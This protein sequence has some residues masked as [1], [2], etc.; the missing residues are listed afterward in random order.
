MQ[1]FSI[2]YIHKN[3]RGLD[4]VFLKILLGIVILIVLILLCPICVLLRYDGKMTVKAGIPFLK[5]RIYPDREDDLLSDELSQKKK[6]K[7]KQ[8]L[9]KKEA[10]A[11]RRREKDRRK[12]KGKK[13]SQKKLS[14]TL[15]Q[16]KGK[17]Y[18]KDLGRIFRF[19]RILAAK[20]GKKLHVKIK[21]LEI[22]AASDDAANTAYLFGALSQAVAYGFA[23]ADK[24]TNIKFKNSRVVVR[25]DFCS[26]KTRV[27]AEI[28]F[29]IRVGSLISFAGSAL[30]LF[31][32]ESMKDKIGELENTP[33]NTENKKGIAL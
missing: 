26:D 16:T 31:A 28:L 22:V 2:D 19:V 10:R 32:K 23:A 7:L 29:R 6:R 9:L 20:F 1:T 24:Y 13:A 14:D 8:K 30:W 15:K 3:E 33:D 5:F 27:N 18:A 11:E 4:T 21:R 25:A 17:G 12:G